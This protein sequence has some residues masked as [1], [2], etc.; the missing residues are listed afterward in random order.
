MDEHP[1]TPI[2]TIRSDSGRDTG[3]EK[4]SLA[5]AKIP[6]LR[7]GSMGLLLSVMRLEFRLRSLGGIR[8]VFESDDV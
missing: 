5:T 8:G 1:A 7:Y 3:G 6:T 2:Q 4:D